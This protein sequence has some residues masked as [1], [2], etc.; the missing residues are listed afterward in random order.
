MSVWVCFLL[1]IAMV[2]AWAL[3]VF[4]EFNKLKDDIGRTREEWLKEQKL[5]LQ[6]ERDWI[7]EKSRLQEEIARLKEEAKSN[8]G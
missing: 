4:H 5:R 6:L 2:S 1:F 8:G 3:V 7:E